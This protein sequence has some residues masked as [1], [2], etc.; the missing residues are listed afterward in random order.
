MFYY[1]DLEVANPLGS[2]RTKHKLGKYQSERKFI[3]WQ[4][5]NPYV[6]VGCFYYLCENLQPKYRGQL[7]NIQ[8]AALV[9]RSLISKYSMDAIL[10]H[11]VEDLLKLVSTCA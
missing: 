10:K 8:L 2:K 11:I 9:K 7:R 1:D 6:H 3:P 4:L 5:I